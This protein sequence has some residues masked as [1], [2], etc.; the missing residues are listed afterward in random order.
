MH[1]KSCGWKNRILGIDS[2]DLGHAT[3]K[4]ALV[5]TSYILKVSELCILK[6]HN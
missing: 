2:S 1:H 5:T 6:A 4:D 3:F